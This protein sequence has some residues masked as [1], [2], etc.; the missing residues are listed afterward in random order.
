MENPILKY[1]MERKRPVSSYEIGRDVLKLSGGALKLVDKIISK[2]LLTNSNVFRDAQGM[3][4]WKKTTV[5]PYIKQNGG[6]KEG[7]YTIFQIVFYKNSDQRL[8]PTGI[9]AY[10]LSQEKIIDYYSESFNQKNPEIPPNYYQETGMPVPSNSETATI[11]ETLI[12]FLEFTD[13]TYLV[14]FHF[15][16]NF[17]ILQEFYQRYFYESF[18]NP[19]ISLRLLAEKLFPDKKYV[20]IQ[21]LLSDISISHVETHEI[22][23]S[24]KTIVALFQEILALLKEKNITSP[25]SI[26]S[27]QL[28]NSPLKL[29]FERLKF[30]PDFFAALP[31]L[32]GVYLME[33]INGEVFYVGK[34]K[35][36]ARRINSHFS[37][38]PPEPQK[39]NIIF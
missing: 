10:R 37:P 24:T 12:S 15:E 14:C 2:S 33:N 31:E 9:A 4:Q 13:E 25:E 34:A 6:K 8:I 23:Q 36:L 26:V 3:W 21:D 35:N 28:Q 18:E 39:Q 29:D 7:S 32:P 11:V 5:E 22:K 1:L 30:T 20:H 16:P 38:M 17:R 27:F 19:V